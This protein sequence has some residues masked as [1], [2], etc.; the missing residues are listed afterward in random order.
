MRQCIYDPRG[1]A[2][3]M[4]WREGEVRP[5]ALRLRAA[6]CPVPCEG[7]EGGGQRQ[8]GGGGRSEG[9]RGS[10]EMQRGEF[11]MAL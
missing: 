11:G 1:K 6:E 8:M 5:L 9:A 10:G 7:E 2:K 3:Q 4:V